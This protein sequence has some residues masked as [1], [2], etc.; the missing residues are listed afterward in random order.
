[1][2]LQ[3][4]SFF[5]GKLDVA[6]NSMEFCG[7]R[8]FGK[9]SM[10]L[11]GTLDLDK[12]PLNPMELEVMLLKFHGIPWNHKCCSNVVL[13]VP[14]ITGHRWIP[15]K[16]SVT[17]S[18]DIFFVLLLN[19]RL[20]KQWWGWWFETPSRPLWRHCNGQYKKL[21]VGWIS[22]VSAERLI[23]QAWEIYCSTLVD[24]IT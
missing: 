19:K 11:H 16:K 6:W 8:E 24:P 20:S 1:M 18:F 13:E 12:I 2:S 5:S 7:T 21:K 14:W 3:K 15:C 9:R 17:R 10:E 23:C 4:S 22:F